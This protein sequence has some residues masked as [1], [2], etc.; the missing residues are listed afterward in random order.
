M[1]KSPIQQTGGARIEVT[2]PGYKVSGLSTTLRHAVSLHHGG[3]SD[4]RG[5]T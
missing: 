3:L 1:A 4:Q 5:P 2:T